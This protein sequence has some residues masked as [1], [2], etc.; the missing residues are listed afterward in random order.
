M[1]G[2]RQTYATMVLG[3]TRLRVNNNLQ[4]ERREAVIFTNVGARPRM[5]TGTQRAR[6][7]V[8]GVGRCRSRICTRRSSR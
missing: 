4:S 2:P 6:P 5:H 3:E 1:P 7:D 8:V